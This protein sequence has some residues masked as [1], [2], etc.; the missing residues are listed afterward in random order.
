MRKAPK[1]AP[2]PKS[3]FRAGN[4]VQFSIRIDE[5]A[6]ECLNILS[7][8]HKTSISNIVKTMIYDDILSDTKDNQ[9]NELKRLRKALNLIYIMGTD[10]RSRVVNAWARMSS[11][12]DVAK[13]ALEAKE[14]DF[15]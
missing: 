6:Y 13:E 5:D 14:E 9:E 7:M 2:K 15:S 11:M 3:G 10:K 12:A 8:Q 4:H 1:M